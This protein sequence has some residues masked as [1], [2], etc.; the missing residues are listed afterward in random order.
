[1]CADAAMERRRLLG[2]LGGETMLDAGP[3]SYSEIALYGDADLEHGLRHA[4]FEPET[5]VYRLLEIPLA[6][7]GETRTMSRWWKNMIPPI[8]ADRHGGA[9]TAAC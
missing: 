1:M 6:A 4:G 5:T 7:A 2:M 3:M 9:A 8:C